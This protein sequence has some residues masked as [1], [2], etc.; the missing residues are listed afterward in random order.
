MGWG[1]FQEF[2]KRNSTSA[3]NAQQSA[4]NSQQSAKNSHLSSNDNTPKESL[5]F[6]KLLVRNSKKNHK[7]LTPYLNNPSVEIIWGDL[8]NY[9]DI[10][11]GVKGADYVLH[12]GG[13]VSPQADFYPEKTLKV[14]VES[15]KNIIRAIHEQPNKDEIGAIYRSI[16]PTTPMGKSSESPHPC[17][18]RLICR[19]QVHCR[20]YFCRIRI[21]KMG[22]HQTNR[23]AIS[24]PS[25]KGKR[26]NHLPR[27]LQRGT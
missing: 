7:L 5:Y 27:P 12:I 26:P 16:L 11:E 21:K 3:K 13:M 4:K 6:L 2:I 10:L 8:L 23:N 19:I 14:N 1:T 9:E 18:T 15:A 25:K 22:I 24:S 20:S 17:K